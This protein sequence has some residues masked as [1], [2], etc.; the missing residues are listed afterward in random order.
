MK[1]QRKWNI[2]LIHHTHLD[3]GYTHTQEDVLKRQY[4]HLE[5]A[6]DL[7]DEH[8]DKPEASQFRWNPE[9]TWALASWYPQA[10]PEEQKRFI[11]MI[12][13]GHIGIDGLYGNLLTG[14]CRPEEIRA[15][16]AYAEIFGAT[17]GVP[18]TSAMITDVPGWNWGVVDALA[19]VGIT[20]LSAGPNRSD[21]IGYT[22]QELGD[23][24]CYWESYSGDKRI[25]LYTHQKGYSWFHTGMNREGARNKLTPRR[26]S[27]YLR[28]LEKENYPYNTILIRYNI[29]SDN[30]PPDARLSGI[31]EQWNQN[32]PEMQIR[33]ST[34]AQA[35][36]D[37]EA[38]YGD[39]LPTY[40]GDITPYWEDGACSTA[41]ET[42]IAREASER[43][44][45][46]APLAEMLGQPLPQPA[47]QH[48][49]DQ[50]LLYNEHTWGAYNSI[51]KPDHP[52]AISQ[53]NWKKQRALDGSIGSKQLI[54]HLTGGVFVDT[55]SYETLLD[56][57]AAS[58]AQSQLQREEYEAP[59]E[60]TVYN[61]QGWET[62][63]IVELDTPY[64]VI[65]NK[66]GNRLCTQ[67]LSNG[68]L[69]LLAQAIPAY[70]KQ[71][72]YLSVESSEEFQKEKSI[73]P[74]NT[75]TATETTLSNGLVRL[76]I[77]PQK[78]TIESIQYKNRELVA[79]GTEHT[80]NQYIFLATK[81]FGIEK[82]A[83]KNPVISIELLEQGPLLATIRI[84][85]KAFRCNSL[86]TDI[87][88]YAHSPKI[89]LTNR[90]DRPIAR[91]K[92]GIHFAF[93]F[94]LPQAEITYDTLRGVA[95]MEK[96]Q[97]P[98]SNR[99]FITATRWVDVSKKAEP[100]KDRTAEVTTDSNNQFGVTTLL[101]DAPIFKVGKPHRDPL[102]MGPPKL[103]GWLDR[104]PLPHNGAIY[105]FVMN[106]YWM[107][108]YKADQPGITLFRYV[109]VPH[110]EFSV[111][112]ANR[113]ALE[114]AQPLIGVWETDHM[115]I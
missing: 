92:E 107:T 39:L 80:F 42:A 15:N 44:S 25:L 108:N 46:I 31:V 110:E 79:Q 96:D 5:K 89:H 7:I 90:L 20:Y 87:T 94:N 27:S 41:R 50:V 86:I 30:G 102:R 49:W 112:E 105:S 29:G 33:I 14:L 61:T 24:P 88:I 18:V 45:Q 16:F 35:M 2:H 55:T 62:T 26:I 57:P 8:R 85:R 59:K 98:A 3:I 67:R 12:Q 100:R 74:E 113:H 71:K 64:S 97:H 28:K 75:I 21:R 115:T 23:K 106:N 13:S 69:T 40:R 22:I 47:Y 109:F 4:A 72:F 103:C 65:T 32:Y 48:A 43:M 52:F 114:T 95:Q 51:S 1:L 60:L 73:S 10:S 76:T 91:K 93:P 68:N 83:P 53:W 58:G 38:T 99:N 54:E 37:F 77:N 101:L 81:F 34:T 6:M 70:G 9:I 36:G 111:D 84:E 82:R 78:G 19:D 56:R 63:D 104:L 11:S 17:S 66:D